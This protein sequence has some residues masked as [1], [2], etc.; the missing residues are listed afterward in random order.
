MVRGR[1]LHYHRHSGRV[2]PQQQMI[3]PFRCDHHRVC[4]VSR[5][6]LPTVLIGVISIAFDAASLTIKQNAMTEHQTSQ[7]YKVAHSWGEG[8]V[9]KEQMSSM[10]EIFL[11]LNFDKIEDDADSFTLESGE[12]VPFLDFVCAKC[13]E[14]CERQKNARCGHL[15]DGFAVVSCRYLEP[16]DE[17]YLKDMFQVMD[18]NRDGL[19]SL[20]EVWMVLL[21]LNINSTCL[22]IVYQT[23]LFLSVYRVS[24]SLGYGLGIL[25]HQVHVVHALSQEA[26]FEW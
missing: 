10:R 4:F 1:F 11:A 21:E 23:L 5:L 26:V 7:I 17:D 24:N 12:L 19:V 15:D 20:P 18:V 6:V 8:Y 13:V 3:C 25:P 2:S 9:S 14:T 16:L 22:R